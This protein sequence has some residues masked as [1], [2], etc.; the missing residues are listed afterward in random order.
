MKRII[1]YCCAALVLLYA[2]HTQCTEEKKP[3]LTQSIAIGSAC[4]ATEVT[5]TGQLSSY[6]MNM[7][8][9]NKPLSRNPLHWYRGLPA[10][11]LSMAPITAIQKTVSNEGQQWIEKQQGHAPSEAQKAAFAFMGG[12]LSAVAGTPG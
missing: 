2:G 5:A 6:A 3:T 11:I 9:Q 10:N 1:N 8:L 7:K 12:T 4:G